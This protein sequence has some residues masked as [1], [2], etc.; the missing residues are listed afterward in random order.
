MRRTGR[1]TRIVNHIVE[2]LMGVGGCIATD[3]AAFEN[4]GFNIQSL[5][6]SI[7]DKVL[8]A[9]NAKNKHSN[10]KIEKTIFDYNGIPAVHFKVVNNN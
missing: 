3:H 10:S 5:E 7:V 4:D 2:Q 8:D 9:Y 6:K 1:T